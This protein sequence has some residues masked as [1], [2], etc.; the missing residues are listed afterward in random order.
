MIVR[1]F[2][3]F[4]IPIYDPDV[5]NWAY[6]ARILRWLTLLWLFIG[7][8]TLF[9]ASFPLANFD[10]GDGLF[11]VKK[12]LIWA[13][14]GLNIFNFLV[15][16]PLKNLLK[17]S[18][19]VFLFLLFLIFLTLIPGTGELRNG[20]SRWLKFGP[21][22]LQPSDLI[23][24]FLVLQGA[25]IFAEWERL[26]PKT[27]WT[28]L[29]IFTLMLGLILQQP[30][31]STTALS[32]IGLWLIALAAGLPLIQL[33]GVALLGL[34][35]GLISISLRSYQLQRINS[36][37]DPF[38]DPRGIG[39]QLV[40]SLYAIGSGGEWGVGFGQS[41]QKLFYLPFQYT[42]F[43]FAI[44]AEEFGFAGGIFLFILLI[45][46]ATLGLFIALKCKQKVKRLVAIG[47]VIF[48]VG[49]S[50]LNIGVNI[51][52]LPTT[53]VTL[54]LFSYGGSSLLASLILAGLL[55]RIAREN[56]EINLISIQKTNSNQRLLRVVK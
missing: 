3:R 51:G 45:C 21:L 16:F 43:I 37:V 17:I 4:L 32:G 38:A 34:C 12:Q 9:S 40:Q 48:L 44:F 50:L 36:F 8:V 15:R 55:T 18:P 30:N 11:Y 2:L 5:E 29:G 14:V 6:E 47:V 20:S 41:Q 35:V 49:Q 56:K 54:P 33:S 27:R 19:L 39:Y 1:S 13:F 46:Y 26:K 10:N 42:D 23:K 22:F 24:P 28:W 53:G 52:S 31:L 25:L 7:L